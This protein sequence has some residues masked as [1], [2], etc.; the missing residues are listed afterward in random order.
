MIEKKNIDI[1]EGYVVDDPDDELRELGLSEEDFR[2]LDE[3]INKEI[4]E[5]VEDSQAQMTEEEK[6]LWAIIEDPNT[7]WEEKEAARRQ[8]DPNMYDEDGNLVLNDGKFFDRVEA[9]MK[10]GLE[11]AKRKGWVAD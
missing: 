1:P 11:E 7:T 6:R 9:M 2:E 10:K 5:L 3:E 4:T 8:L